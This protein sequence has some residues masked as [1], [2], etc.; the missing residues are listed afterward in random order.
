VNPDWYRLDD[1]VGICGATS[2]PQWLME[3]VANF[4]LNTPIPA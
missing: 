1:H 4:V 3:E 2:T